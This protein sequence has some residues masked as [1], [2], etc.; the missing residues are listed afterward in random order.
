[1]GRPSTRPPDE[2]IGILLDYV[3]GA[4]LIRRIGILSWKEPASSAPCSNGHSYLG[5]I[6]YIGR[7][8]IIT[9]NAGIAISPIQDLTLTLQQYLFWRASD[10]DSIYNKSSAVFRQALPMRATS[11]RRQT[12][13]R[14]ITSPGICR[15]TR[16]IASSPVADLSKKP[17]AT[18][19]ATSSTR[20]CSTRSETGG[21]A[22]C[23]IQRETSLR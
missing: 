15:A 13:S 20:H 18:R 6:D 9:P 1:M 23:S 3:R 16:A 2:K 22:S 8:N 7:Q 17:A 11:V 10:R 19:I 12:C 14:L 5:Y 21:R 4:R